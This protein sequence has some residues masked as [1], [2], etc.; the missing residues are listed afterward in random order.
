MSYIFLV[1][2]RYWLARVQSNK[3]LQNIDQCVQGNKPNLSHTLPVVNSKIFAKI[4]CQPFS[5]TSTRRRKRKINYKGNCKVFCVTHKCYNQSPFVSHSLSTLTPTQKL[6]AIT[7]SAIT[8]S[9]LTI[10][11]LE[12]GVK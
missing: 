9:K 4:F 2:Q 1:L 3:A 6:N 8:C 5:Q 12:Q 11:T 10:E 7:Q